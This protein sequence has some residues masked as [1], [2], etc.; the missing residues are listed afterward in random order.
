[1]KTASS[2][3]GCLNL[4]AYGFEHK[5]E[6]D[7]ALAYYNKALAIYD[8]VD[9][10][11]AVTQLSSISYVHI[12]KGEFKEA[13]D[14]L[15]RAIY[16]SRI[17]KDSL[18]LG[19]ALQ[20]T[21]FLYSLTAE[22][23]KG[24]ANND[25]A[26]VI[27]KKS[28][29]MTRLASTY[30][31]RGTL[32]SS[33][34]EYKSSVN[35]H[36]VS[37]SLYKDELMEDQRGI[38]FNNIGIVYISQS[39][40]E[41]ALKYLN[42]SLATLKKGVIDESYIL[43]NG[44]I[45]ECLVGL[46]RTNEAKTLL[47][48]ILPRAQK[49][50]L[51]RIGSGM[52]LILGKIFFDEGNLRQAYE[53]Y[54]YA[55]NSSIASGEKE[56]SIDALTSLGRVYVIEK[57][58]DSAKISFQKGVAMA[59]QYK[60]EGSWNAFYELGLLYYE[61]K[62]YDSSITYFKQA[63]ELLDKNAEN[64]FGGEEAKKI[65][66]NDPQKSDLYNKIT[67]SYYNIGNI[68]EAWAYANRSNIAGIKELSG[69]L[70]TNSSDE[71]RNS[72]LK[73]LLAMQQSKKALENN[74]EKQTGTAKEE[75]LKKIEILEADYNNFLQDVVEQYPELSTYFTRSNADEF[76]NYKGKLDDDVAVALYLVNGKTL[77][78]FTLTNE[79][80]AV[81]TMTLDITPRITT[82]IETIKNT[83]KQTGTGPL[84]ERSDPQDEEKVNTN[85]EF[86][87]ISDELYRAL[88]A[89][90]YD[91]I[92]SK[93][94]LCIIPTGIFSN[95]PFQC[96]GRKMPDNNFRF[97][98]EDHCVFYTNKMSVFNE[99][100]KSDLTN[101]GLKS[102]AAFGVP[103]AT[104][105]FNISEVQNI[106][107]ILGS[108]STIYTDSRATESMAKQSLR[109]KKFIHFATH[110]VLNYSSDYSESYLKLL[111]DKDS[112][113]GNNG[114]L[115]M[116]EV[117]KLGI[118]DCN[119]VILS[120]C[121]TAVTKQLVKGW[122]IS[123]ANSFLVSHVKTVVASLW[124]VADE[125]TGILMEYFY[126]NLSKSMGKAEALRQAQI[127]LSQ[128]ARF[129]HPNYWGAFVLYGEWQ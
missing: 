128:D 51:E 9:K 44:N 127:K 21:S 64:L 92:S 1:M 122:N 12:S 112:S 17:N 67:F 55:L 101:A 47:M 23:D 97:L 40:Y 8:T 11:N 93:K 57:K 39:D 103:D 16:I 6:L 65:F 86:K 73:K 41:N 31:S 38:V 45:A 33:M 96:L 14:A 91:K 76:N 105:H 34:G 24:L 58:I 129:R 29:N 106:G 121:Q 52:A 25:S 68:K 110:G 27:F 42:K 61:Q 43:A 72:A 113:D 15:T 85:V 50:K 2:W 120:A 26:M 13:D 114:R 77:M 81:D 124:K 115:T 63:V 60:T 36:L 22:F 94:K 102:F 83:N 56:K 69:T 95:M 62:Q 7:S 53:Y 78:I 88:I 18:A 30:G 87:D 37:D 79:K 10:S 48:D 19:S 90:V 70:S 84:S 4:K 89:T 82:F 28:G 46:K 71:E 117:Q 99:K 126:E 98:I 100:N 109:N 3:A 119:M 116:R 59:A 74:L 49:M 107:K 125:P 32:L 35:A 108:D 75:T 80:L 104:L 111:P 123:P 54:L 118:T 5:T 66:N 20:A